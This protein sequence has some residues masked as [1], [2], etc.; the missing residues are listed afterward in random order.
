MND[1]IKKLTELT[2]AGEM[3]VK[4]VPT[5]FDRTDLF[6]DRIEMES[7]RMCEY[8]LNQEPMI[9]PYSAFTGFFRF[10]GSVVGDAFKRGGHRFTGEGMSNFYLKPID[11]LSTMEWQHA[12]ADYRKVLGKGIRGIIAEIDESLTCHT[13]PE[14]ISFL[15][16]LRLTAETMIKWAHKCSARAI[17][18]AESQSDIDVKQRLNRLSEALMRVPENAPESFYEAVLCIYVCF[19]ADPDS[20]GTLDRYLTP[21]YF[22]DIANGRLTKDSATEYLQELFLMVQAHTSVSASQFTRGGESHF[23]IGG[24]L[25][26]GSDCFN[27]VSRLI[28]EALTDLPTYIPQITLRWTNKLAREDFRWMMDMERRDPH[29]RIAFTNDEKRIK[30]FTEFCGFP[31]ERAVEYTMVG[32]NEPAF[33]GAITGSNSK[34]NILRSVETLFHEKSDLIKNCRDFEEFYGVFEKEMYSDLDLIYYYDDKYNS[35][36]ARDYNYISSLFFNDC[37]ENAKSLTQGGGDV[38]I[39]S[40]MLLG[41]TNVIDSLIVI[42]QFVYDEEFLTMGELIDA[43]KNN[44]QGYEIQ[45]TVMMRKGTF[46]GNDDDRSNTVAARLYE[47]FYKYLKGKKNLFGYPFIVGDLLGYNE[48]HKWFGEKTKA[49]PD[50]RHDGDLIKFGLGQSGGRDRNGLTALLNSIAAVDKNAAACGTTVTNIS[51]DEQLIKNDENFEK[52]VE[53]F[54][55]YFKNGGVHFQLTYVSRED[56]LAAKETPE[57]YRHLRVRVTG[58]SDYFVK[59][60]P[61]IQNDIIDRTTKEGI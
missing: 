9:T 16:A 17:E 23:C 40:P 37:I 38:V 48:H 43:V 5:S 24:Y 54:E 49:T 12:T 30:C 22:N 27:D 15:K 6:L 55:T 60:L 8:I 1:R 39:T 20:F 57:D 34:G 46:F 21:F 19:S 35:L 42:K 33:L 11:N 7:K 61:S 28:V 4:P 14:E 58:F 45:Y 29:K 13:Q 51:I 47:S 41:I 26:D 56:L 31:Y 59:L 10:D 44:W 52:T 53:L 3:Y 50:G 36:R 2:L 32:C 25:P 18:Y